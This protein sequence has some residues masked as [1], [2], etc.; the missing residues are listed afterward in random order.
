MGHGAAGE[1]KQGKALVD[2]A[3][4]HGVEFF[5]YSSV[6]RNGE[7]SLSNPTDIP[8]FISKHNIEKHL[9][10]KTNGGEGQ[11]GYT[12]LRPVAFMDNFTA[13]FVGKVL[14][15]AWESTIPKD[16]PLQ[17][18]ATKD[19]GTF[20]AKAF[21]EPEKYNKREIALAGDSLTHGEM[22]KVFKEKTGKDVP[23]TYWFV[24]WAIMWLSKELGTM[25]RW[26]GRE[27]YGADVQACKKENPGMM[28][29]GEWLEKE[30]A[31]KK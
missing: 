20:A 17:L 31:Y 30:S 23:Q 10:A 27:G 1:E 4:S 6:D 24:A 11:M 25:V 28:D 22:A 29:F 9:I 15:T 14:P 7:K 3:L 8:H 16:K 12:I 13:D 5:V 19:I 26:F 2:A 21:E 18:V